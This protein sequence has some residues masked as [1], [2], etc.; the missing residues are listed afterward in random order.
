MGCRIYTAIFILLRVSIVLRPFSLFYRISCCE[1][2]LQSLASTELL[3]VTVL[4]QCRVKAFQ[5]IV[6]ETVRDC[7]GRSEGLVLI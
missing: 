4:I 3:F 2:V 6:A 5:P 7:D 1:L